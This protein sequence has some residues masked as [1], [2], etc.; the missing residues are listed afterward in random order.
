MS[1]KVYPSHDTLVLFF[2]NLE[3]AT[4]KWLNVQKE[5]KADRNHI[6]EISESPT[7]KGH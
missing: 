1:L 7:L 3:N 5:I 6:L 2:F 4:I